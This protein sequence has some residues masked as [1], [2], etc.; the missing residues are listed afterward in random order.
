MVVQPI[1]IKL[2]TKNNLPKAIHHA[3]PYLDATTWVVSV[4]TQFVTVRILC[5]SYFLV[6]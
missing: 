3:K 1:L 5:L 6:S 2:E 4:Y